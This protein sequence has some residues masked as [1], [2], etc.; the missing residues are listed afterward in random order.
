MRT[1]GWVAACALVS[2]SC[3]AGAQ[4]NSAFVDPYSLLGKPDESPARRGWLPL[5]NLESESDWLDRLRRSPPKVAAAFLRWSPTAPRISD[6]DL[7]LC[8]SRP[9]QEPERSLLTYSV[10]VK[11]EFVDG[12]TDSVELRGS[13]LSNFGLERCTS[14]PE[15]HLNLG[16]GWH[17]FSVRAD[18]RYRP[19]RIKSV[20]AT[21]HRERETAIHTATF[22]PSLHIYPTRPTKDGDVMPTRQFIA[23]RVRGEAL[24][25]AR[26]CKNIAATEEITRPAANDRSDYAQGFELGW[27]LA[28]R[29]LDSDERCDELPA[30]FAI[31]EVGIGAA[32]RA[33]SKCERAL[34]L[35]LP[36]EQVCLRA[37]E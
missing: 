9:L 13:P 11:V 10:Q 14:I 5:W 36:A 17:D 34:G 27:G 35:G 33:V 30:V 12:A 23:G 8:L 29:F 37:S 25:S 20:S 22:T 4:P 32:I 18:L 16:R 21:V 2:C 19:G 26:R 24:R 31:E 6:F 1:A 28:G 7:L 15:Q 3:I